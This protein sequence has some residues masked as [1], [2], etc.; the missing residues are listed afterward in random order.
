VLE[1]LGY[2]VECARDGAEAI[3]L[4]EAARASGRGFDAVL[5]DLTVPGGMGGKD[6]AAKLRETDPFVPLIVSRGYS[7][8]PILSEFRK[9]GFDAVLRKPWTAAE[10]S[11]IL[12]KVIHAAGR[13]HAN[14]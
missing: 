13:P 7:E 10:L 2:Q 12:K 4:Y 5:L 3:A 1:Q 14:D 11:E 9:H 6:T 8:A